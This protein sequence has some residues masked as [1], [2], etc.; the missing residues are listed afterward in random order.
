MSR[1]NKYEIDFGS[2]ELH[3]PQAA[4]VLRSVFDLY[5]Q[6]AAEADQLLARAETLERSN[7]LH[8]KAEQLADACAKVHARLGVTPEKMARALEQARTGQV[9]PA[10]TIRDE[11]RARLHR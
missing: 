2:P 7:Q 6:W 3:D 10:E 5:V 1:L 4:E 8:A 9:I 11:L